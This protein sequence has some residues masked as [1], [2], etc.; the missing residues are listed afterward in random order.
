MFRDA[1]AADLDDTQGGTT[2]EGIHLGAMA[3]TIDLVT[4]A[5]AGL[6]TRSDSLIFC[7]RLPDEVREVRFEITFRGQRMDVCINHDRLHLA[8]HPCAGAPHIH[9]EVAGTRVMLGGGQEH[10]FRTR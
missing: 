5:F 2:E 1:L 3:G 9:V 6:Q 8:V 7:P 10:E 4:R